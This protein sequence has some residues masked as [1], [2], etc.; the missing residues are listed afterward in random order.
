MLLSIR[1][2]TLIGIVGLFAFFKAKELFGPD[3]IRHR[4]PKITFKALRQQ[5]RR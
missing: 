1:F 5:P 2:G 3:R 4:N